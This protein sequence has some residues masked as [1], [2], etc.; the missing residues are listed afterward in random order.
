[1]GRRRMLA[2]AGLL[3]LAA[4]AAAALAGGLVAGGHRD[5]PAAR[6]GQLVSTAQADRLAQARLVNFR[7]GR[8]SFRAVIQASGGDVHVVGTVDWSRPLVYLSSTADQPGPADGLVQAVPGL[9]AVHAGRYRPAGPSLGG[10]E[11]P[12]PPQAP[13]GDGWRLRRMNPAAGGSAFDT[14]LALLFSL[15]APRP[16]DPAALSRARVSVRTGELA[17]QT[18]EVFTGP[19]LTGSGTPSGR[20][21]PS[22]APPGPATPASPGPV[23]PGASAGSRSPLPGTSGPPQQPGIG[24]TP[25]QPAGELLTG[26]VAS[27]SAS[28]GLP[29]VTGTVQYWLDAAG[30]MRRVV[31]SLAGGLPV[32]VDLLDSGPQAL[33]TVAVLGG[34]PATARPLRDAEWALL[35]RMR[36]RDRAAGGGTV[37]VTLPGDLGGL[38]TAAGWLNWRDAVGYLAVHDPDDADEDH[39]LRF[40]RTSLVSRDGAAGAV[41]PLK[42]PTDDWR[43]SSWSARGDGLGATDLDILLTQAVTVTST[44]SEPDSL[45]AHASALRTDRIGPVPV[46]IVEVLQASEAGVPAGQGRLRYWLDSSGLLRRVEL[47]T[48]QGGFGWL[49]ITPG[50][51]PPLPRPPVS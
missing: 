33:V 36:T 28:T 2:I 24:T 35:S 17:G 7:D 22:S 6:P 15:A 16:D 42:P 37:T 11:Y 45:R 43:A 48:R 34:A 20:P 29:P 21:A 25:G 26:P 49:D 30:R 1:M 44:R 4:L 51:V 5:R 47:R 8:A 19:A 13:P 46:L 18:A 31:A 14:L 9:V 27:P 41:P 10:D 50:T 40:D 39:L 12:T 32:Q 38:T 3:V 23:S